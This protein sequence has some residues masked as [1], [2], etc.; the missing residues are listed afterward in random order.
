MSL[1]VSSKPPGRSTRFPR[2][3]S[4]QC[5]GCLAGRIAEAAGIEVEK[6]V[7]VGMASFCRRVALH[8][9]TTVTRSAQ[10]LPDQ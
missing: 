2:L 8:T 7:R 4:S 9:V 10:V 5:P 3:A 6:E 1:R